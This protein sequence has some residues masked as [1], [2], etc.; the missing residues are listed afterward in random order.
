MVSWRE[1]LQQLDVKL[2]ET[3][4]DVVAKTLLRN[5]KVAGR[6]FLIY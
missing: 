2:L 4:G 1:W 5:K 3:E 6:S